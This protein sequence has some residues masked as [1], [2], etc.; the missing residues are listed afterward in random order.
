MRKIVEMFSQIGSSHATLGG[1]FWHQKD[2]SQVIDPCSLQVCFT[3]RFSWLRMSHTNAI[4]CPLRNRAAHRAG[5]PQSLQSGS[6]HCASE[7]LKLQTL[8]SQSLTGKWRVLPR[9]LHFNIFHKNKENNIPI[10][11]SDCFSRSYLA[12]ESIPNRWADTLQFLVW[13]RCPKLSLASTW[14]S[15]SLT[16]FDES[17]F[18]CHTFSHSMKG[19][20]DQKHSAESWRFSSFFLCCDSWR[21]MGWVSGCP[22]QILHLTLKPK[23][24]K[25][26]YFCF[27]STYANA[28]FHMHWRR[29]LCNAS[30]VLCWKVRSNSKKL[31]GSNL[32][33]TE[34]DKSDSCLLPCNIC[35]H[36]ETTSSNGLSPKN[37]WVWEVF[38]H[39]TIS[40]LVSMEV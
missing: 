12:I 8:M 27:A 22:L 30:L 29:A 38:S 33:T 10:M 19:S 28:S 1:N 18:P 40:D 31:L 26:N 3:W 36:C 24:F 6:R 4:L 25:D 35:W 39:Q 9:V 2:I 16:R 5:Q 7:L 14:P 23:G 15:Q 32:H 34:F 13:L 37:G 20:R 21:A 11:R 17:S